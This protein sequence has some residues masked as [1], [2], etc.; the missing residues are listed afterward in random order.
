MVEVP[1]ENHFSENRVS[2]VDK[3]GHNRYVS[4]TD[5][6]LYYF[7]LSKHRLNKVFDIQSCLIVKYLISPT[8]TKSFDKT[9]TMR[10]IK[11]ILWYE[12]PKKISRKTMLGYSF[13]STKRVIA[14]VDVWTVEITK[15]K[16]IDYYSLVICMYWLHLYYCA[17]VHLIYFSLLSFVFLANRFSFISAYQTCDKISISIRHTQWNRTN[18]LHAHIY[19]ERKRSECS[20]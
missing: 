19:I 5:D 3:K 10:R 9:K 16:Y 15:K 4:L 6:R 18:K 8:K 12:Q 2:L 7:S 20:I 13:G 11:Y 1:L 14:G 17:W